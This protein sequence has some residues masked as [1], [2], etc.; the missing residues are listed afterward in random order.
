MGRVVSPWFACARA[1]RSECRSGAAA[2]R[3]ALLAAL[4]WS[5]WRSRSRAV[6]VVAARA[7]SQALSFGA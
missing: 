4:Q 3:T 5:R 7:A 6:V 2:T 1:R